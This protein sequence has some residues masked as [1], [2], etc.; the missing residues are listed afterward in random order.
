MRARREGRAPLRLYFS[1]VFPLFLF[2]CWCEIFPGAVS[3]GPF[4]CFS[5]W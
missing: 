3:F 4:F 5:F 1:F 2:F